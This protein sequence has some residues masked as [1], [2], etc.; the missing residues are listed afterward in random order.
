[1]EVEKVVFHSDPLCNLHREF[2]LKI[3]Q[4]HRK[5]KVFQLPPPI[6]SRSSGFFGSDKVLACE[7]MSQK[8]QNEVWS[9]CDINTN[10]K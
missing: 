10:K 2:A 4:N 9:E 5:S 7:V 3:D 1:M 6:S 8:S